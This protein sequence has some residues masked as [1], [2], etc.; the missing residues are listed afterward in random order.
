VRVQDRQQYDKVYRDIMKSPRTIV[1]EATVD[2][3]ASRN[4]R[5]RIADAVGTATGSL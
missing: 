5:E 1:I 3:G 4:H 2:P